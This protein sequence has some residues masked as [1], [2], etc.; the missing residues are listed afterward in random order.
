M[1]LVPNNQSTH[2]DKHTKSSI[3]EKFVL[4]VLKF[5]TD[6]FSVK[7][8]MNDSIQPCLSFPFKCLGQEIIYVF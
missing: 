5:S 7:K 8:S 6:R 1:F 4:L 3:N 2:L